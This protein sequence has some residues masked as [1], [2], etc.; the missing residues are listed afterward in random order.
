MGQAIV[1]SHSRAQT[2]TNYQ[3]WQAISCKFP[4]KIFPGNSVEKFSP[5]E[6]SSSSR[7][8]P[9]RLLALRQNCKKVLAN[10]LEFFTLYFPSSL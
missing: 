7:A 10:F 5:I 3:A 8:Q 4:G 6:L 2:T 9:R 1:S